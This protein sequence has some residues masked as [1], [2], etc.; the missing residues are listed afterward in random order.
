[1]EEYPE[2]NEDNFK[3][4]NQRLL[5]TYARTSVEDVES[6][7]HLAEFIRTKCKRPN[8]IVIVA[9]EHHKD[10]MEHIHVAVDFRKRFQSQNVRIFD[11]EDR[12]PNIRKILSMTHWAN[13]RVY[14]AKEDKEVKVNGRC[15]DAAKVWNCTSMAEA[16]TVGV[17]PLRA[18]ILYECKDEE[19]RPPMIRDNMAWYEDVDECIAR[20]KYRKINWFCDK[21]GNTG[22]TRY[23]RWALDRP[24]KDVLAMKLIARDTD[25]NFFIAEERKKGWTGEVLILDLPRN[26]ADRDSIYSGIETIKDGFGNS[27]KYTCPSF[28]LDNCVVIVFANWLPKFEKLSLDRW[29]VFHIV[30]KDERARGLN[31]KEARALSKRW[32]SNEE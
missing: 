6:K 17:D 8:A 9:E 26:M 20:K 18:K 3:I 25:F 13:V 2:I 19:E 1:M 15:K 31:L 14:L 29:K 7:E 11:Y 23:C 10:G 22:K 12:H 4:Q 32:G 30:S 28:R 27:G 16:M 24:Q 21:V 5:L